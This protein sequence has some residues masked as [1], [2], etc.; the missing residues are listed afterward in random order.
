[1][2]ITVWRVLCVASAVLFVAGLLLL[3]FTRLLKNKYYHVYTADELMTKSKMTNGKNSV[4]FTSGETKNYINKYAICKTEFD[5]YLVCKFVKKFSY[6]KY[7]VLEYSAH[8][9]VIGVQQID[10]CDTGLNSK[11]IT[12]HKRCA[13]VN[14]VIG[15]ADD[16]EINSDVIRPLSRK[17]IRVFALIKSFTL[18]AFLFAV[19]HIILEVL[20]KGM[21]GYY[22]Q[23]MLNYISIGVCFLIGLISYGI[24]VLC[25]RRKNVKALNGGVVEYEFV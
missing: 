18:F 20:C 17:R 4:Y 10:E 9:R 7:F 11:I 16:V 13:K 22:L 3:L 1:M 14:V 15:T 5:R 25:F 19:R 12:L 23:D 24:T 2:T 8:G 21:L 6:V